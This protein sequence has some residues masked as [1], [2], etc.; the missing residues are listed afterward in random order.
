MRDYIIRRLLL[1]IPIMLL[2]SFMTHATFR[3]IPGSAAHLICGLQCTEESIE[4]IEGK[5]GLDE[6]FFRQYGEWLGVWPDDDKGNKFSGVLQGDF[7]ESFLNS[8]QSVTDR[9]ARTMPVTA[10]LMILSL[11]FAV[12]LGIPP[13]VLSAIRPGTLVDLV[14]R[15]TSVAWLSVPNF[16]LAILVIAFGSN[17]FGWLPPNFGTGNA[18]RIWEDPLQNMET[19]FFPSLVL[20]LGIAA[21]IMRLTRSSM[22]E[23][24]RNDYVRTAWSKGLKERTVV[25]RHALKNAMIPVLTIIGLQVGALIGG[26]VLIES[27]FALNGMGA[28]LL[29]SV[30]GRDLLVVQSL[31]LIFA[32]VF[33]VINLVVDV[34]YAWLDPRI[35]YG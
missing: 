31:V 35:R 18:V 32:L 16:Y 13:G 33:V 7:G 28:Y 9:L 24:M 26:S 14:V 34:A 19:F 6:N 5:Y 29:A 4:A 3:I 21:V 22:L 15:M 11:I 12:A 20:S 23:V 30:I 2:V 10:E 25:W 8:G 1:L 27:V 17:W